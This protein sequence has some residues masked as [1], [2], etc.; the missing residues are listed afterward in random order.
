MKVPFRVI[1]CS[2]EDP[3][4]PI[5]N[6]VCDLESGWQSIRFST[7]PQLLLLQFLTPDLLIRELKITAHHAKISKFIEVYACSLADVHKEL[8]KIQFRK[9]GEMRFSDNRGNNFQKREVQIAHTELKASYMKFVFHE[10]Y[11]NSQNPFNQIG[12]LNISIKANP[13]SFTNYLEKLSAL[14]NQI[15]P[16]NLIEN[17]NDNEKMEVLKFPDLN[18]SYKTLLTSVLDEKSTRKYKSL[19]VEKKE[20]VEREDFD[21]AQVLKTQMD[22]ILFFG[23]YSTELEK[24]TQ[25]AMEQDDFDTVKIL[26]AELQRMQNNLKSK[27][28]LKG[29]LILRQEFDPLKQ[30]NKEKLVQKSKE[31]M[32]FSQQDFRKNQAASINMSPLKSKKSLENPKEFKNEIQETSLEMQFRNMSPIK[33]YPIPQNLISDLNPKDQKSNLQ[34]PFLLTENPKTEKSIMQDFKKFPPIEEAPDLNMNDSIPIDEITAEQ[35]A[36]CSP[37]LG[38]LGEEICFKLFHEKWQRRELGLLE[39]EKRVI[40]DPDFS[41]SLAQGNTT[42]NLILRLFGILCKDKIIKNVIISLELLKRVLSEEIIRDKV[43]GSEFVGLDGLWEGLLDRIGDNCLKITQLSREIFCILTKKTGV[44]PNN[45]GVLALVKELEKEKGKSSLSLK[46]LEERVK[47]LTE[48]MKEQNNLSDNVLSSVAQFCLKNIEH[49]KNT[50]RDSAFKV[51]EALK[52]NYG[53]VKLRKILGDIP[54]RLEI[55]LFA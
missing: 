32:G 48:L 13:Q 4:F 38:L 10:N 22:Q 2:G 14:D 6:I 53:D 23:P 7:Y 34:E 39:L 41:K 42:L 24:R 29:G 30:K 40:Q 27:L 31:N 8:N 26:K 36:L 49:Q 1:F 19:E 5:S 45:P 46:H 54:R 12:I 55:K 50:I 52:G 43:I 33:N 11:E 28:F 3:E 35:K 25:K 21:Q 47:L 18:Y 9:I 20:A 44:K 16:K 37:F 15:L 17:N 51:L